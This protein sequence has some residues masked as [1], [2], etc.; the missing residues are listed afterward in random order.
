MIEESNKVIVA[1]LIPFHVKESLDYLEESIDSIRYQ[2]TK[3][4]VRIYLGID[5]PLN[6]DIESFLARKTDHIYKTI[7]NDGKNGLA[8]I[9]NQMIDSLEDEFFVFRQDADDISLPYRIEKQV[10]HMIKNPTLDVSGGYILEF[11][12][13]GLNQVITY[14]L[15][16]EKIYKSMSYRCPIAHPT[17]CFRA[18]IFKKGHRYPTETRYN[19]DM[20]FWVSLLSNNLIFSNLDE[21]L[22]KFRVTE[23]FYVKRGIKSAKSDIYSFYLANRKLNLGFHKLFFV[24]MRLLLKVSPTKIIR[25]VYRSKIRNYILKQK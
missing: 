14:P 7:H 6:D 9:L 20:F 21:V 10:D 13:K 8:V 19:Q 23:K 22:L 16:H 5:G 3:H 18:E 11:D 24:A 4:E 12:T 17:V 25:A 2:E 15:T 1:V